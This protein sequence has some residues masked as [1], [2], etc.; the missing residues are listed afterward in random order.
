MIGLSFIYTFGGIVFA[1][2]ALLSARDRANPKRWGNAAFWGLL[3]L[4]F[5][6]GNAL[7]DLG[8]GVLVLVLVALAGFGAI[9][10]SHPPTTD[11]ATR[12]ASAAKFGNRLFV[13]ALAIPVTALAGTLLFKYITVGGVPLVDPKQTT[14]VSLALGVLVALALATAMLRPPKLASLQEGRRLVDAVGWAAI[15]PQMLAALGGVFALAGVGEAFFHGDAG[16][17]AEGI[18]AGPA[19]PQ[20]ERVLPDAVVARRGVQLQMFVQ[21]LGRQLGIAAALALQRAAARPGHPHRALVHRQRRGGGLHGLLRGLQRG[22]WY[23]MA[24]TM[25]AAPALA[26]PGLA[27]ARRPRGAERC[28][29]AVG[30]VGRPLGAVRCLAGE[31]ACRA[32]R[33]HAG[34]EFL[35]QIHL[36]A[37]GSLHRTWR[38]R[39]LASFFH[40]LFRGNAVEIVHRHPPAAH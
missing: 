37:H 28:R 10:R 8:N 36:H 33:H 7:G 35:Q 11:A 31:C 18:V 30:A 27:P 39:T 19:A 5:L 20:A 34:P 23:A 17:A 40:L 21:R 38:P 15:L 26:Q 4:N 6:G 1:A 14:L 25:L 2:I 9:G 13:P 24:Q 16:G 3:A 22:C 12:S 29:P 32:R